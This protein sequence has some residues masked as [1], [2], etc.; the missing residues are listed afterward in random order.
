MPKD[1]NLRKQWFDNISKHQRVTSVD[2]A[3][4]NFSVCSEHFKPENVHKTK[5]RI[6]VNTYPTIFPQVDEASDSISDDYDFSNPNVLVK[7][8]EW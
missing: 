7:P 8:V 6:S 5:S 2:L 3:T 1:E 4:I